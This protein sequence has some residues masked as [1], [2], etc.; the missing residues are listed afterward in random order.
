MA[1]GM[2]ASGRAAHQKASAGD[3]RAARAVISCFPGGA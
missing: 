3:G 1:S 2:G